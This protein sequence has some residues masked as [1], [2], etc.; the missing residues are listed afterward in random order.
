M[1]PQRQ[2]ARH[3]EAKPATSAQR[4]GQLILGDARGLASRAADA[5]STSCRG[6]PPVSGT[7][8]RSSRAGHQIVQRTFRRTAVE[9][10]ASLTATGIE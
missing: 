10:P 7:R 5:E 6:T 8:C 9:R 1:R 2:L 3:L 4:R